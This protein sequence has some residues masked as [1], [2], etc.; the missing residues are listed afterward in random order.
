MKFISRI[1]ELGALLVACVAFSI[2][3]NATNNASI[4]LH[5]GTG[6][7][8]ATRLLEQAQAMFTAAAFSGVVFL[9]LFLMRLIRSFVQRT[10]RD[11]S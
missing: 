7:E 2:G 9:M 11:S 6:L 3:F 1:I 10:H 4:Y 8:E 5:P